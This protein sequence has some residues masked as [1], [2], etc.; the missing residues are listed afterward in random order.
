MGVPSMRE[1]LY[2]SLESTPPYFSLSYS[3]N[4]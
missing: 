3:L 1:E 4:R 2:R